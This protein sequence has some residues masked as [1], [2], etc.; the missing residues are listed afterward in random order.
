VRQVGIYHPRGDTL[1]KKGGYYYW[2][3]LGKKM[4]MWFF[5][6]RTFYDLVSA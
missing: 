4:D 5:T 3:F 6:S 2:V 1:R